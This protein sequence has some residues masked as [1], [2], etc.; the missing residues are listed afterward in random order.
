MEVI[1]D[2]EDKINAVNYLLHGEKPERSDFVQSSLCRLPDYAESRVQVLL[3]SG[4]TLFRLGII[5]GF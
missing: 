4:V 1:N 3:Y 2:S 5:V